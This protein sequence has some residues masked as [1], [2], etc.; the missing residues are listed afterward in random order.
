MSGLYKR[1][2]EVLQ[3]LWYTMESSLEFAPSHFS[4]SHSNQALDVAQG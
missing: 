3:T 2:K 4:L 1:Q